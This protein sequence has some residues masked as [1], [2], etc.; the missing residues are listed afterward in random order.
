MWFEQRGHKQIMCGY[1]DTA[2]LKGN[3]DSWM[4][5]TDGVD[6]VVGLMYTQW[7]TGHER[8]KEFFELA[9]TY[10]QWAPGL[11]ASRG[12]IGVRER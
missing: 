8:M 10:D 3:I 1:Y 9:R 2:D 7:S 6:G 4:K 5:V 11:K 12:D